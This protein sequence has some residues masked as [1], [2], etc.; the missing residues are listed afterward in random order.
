[1]S[2]AELILSPGIDTVSHALEWLDGIAGEA[3]WPARTVHALRLSLD[4]TLTNITMYGFT[5]RAPDMAEP[6]IRLQLQHDATRAILTVS[7]NGR[8]FDPTARRPR[9]LDAS[10]DDAQVGGHGLRLMLHFLESM[11]YERAGDW[12]RLELVARI[13]ATP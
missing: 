11:H 13:D 4:E 2:T 3:G 10:L 8:A 1:M 6:R 5:D 12:N 7:D 9:E